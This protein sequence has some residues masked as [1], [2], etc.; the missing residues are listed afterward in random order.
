WVNLRQFRA[1][2]PSL[3]LE[4]AGATTRWPNLEI[5]DWDTRATPDPSLVYADGLHLTPAGQAAMAE[6]IAQHLDAYVR[7]RVSAS[8]S[9]STTTTTAA[10]PTRRRAPH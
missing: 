3:N 4:L 1:F 10:A 8:T 5:A 9:T 2:V 6:L 7:S